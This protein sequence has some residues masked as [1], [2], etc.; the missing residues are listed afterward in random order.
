LP[1]GRLSGACVNA[2]AATLFTALGVLRLLSSLL[3]FVATL[4]DVRSLF[5]IRDTPG[6]FRADL[7]AANVVANF[8]L[9]W[10]RSRPTPVPD[11]NI[12]CR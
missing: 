6:R 11:R 9:S 7:P 8:F 1:L 2:D 10:R 12:P 5:A 3:A 4:G